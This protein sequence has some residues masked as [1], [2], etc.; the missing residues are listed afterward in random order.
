[1]AARVR[2][3]VGDSSMGASGRGTAQRSAVLATLRSSGRFRTAQEI[4]SELRQSGA[5]VGLTTVYRHL[6][7]LADSGVIHAV[8]TA[9]RQT[10]YRQCS[11]TSPHHHLICVG[12]GAGVEITGSE[13]DDWVESLAVR[14]G[15]TDV[16]HSLEIRGLCPACADSSPSHA[17]SGSNRTESSAAQLDWDSKKGKR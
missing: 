14:L 16:S 7:K 2:V 3:E 5:R 8:Q 6:Q 1:M 10:A 12:C 13:T 4:Y 15:Y 9:S 11:T 17:V